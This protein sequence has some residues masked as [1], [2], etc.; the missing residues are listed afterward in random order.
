LS[1]ERIRIPLPDGQSV[2]GA[3]ALP[4]GRSPRAAVLFAHGAGQDME[5]PLGVAVTEALTAAGHVTLRFNF[6]YM[7]HGKRPP[8]QAPVLESTL[9]AAAELLRPLGPKLVLAGKSMGGRYASIV[10]SKG[11][12]CAGLFFLGYPLHPAG[13]PAKLRDAHLPAVRVPMLFVQGT[14]DS[15]AT[16]DLLRPVVAELGARAT[17]HVVE[18]G[19]HS[20]DVLKSLRRSKAYVVEE[21]VGVIDRWIEGLPARRGAAC[22]P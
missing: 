1:I 6:L 15:L 5:N 22:P 2:T 10:A 9:R 21:I 17:L 14:R 3:L 19:D 12:A 4:A 11:F 8:D 20:L 13:K 18:G 7:E 16:L